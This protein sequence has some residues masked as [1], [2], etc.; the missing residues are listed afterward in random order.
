MSGIQGFRQ[1]TRDLG[2]HCTYQL[3]LRWQASFKLQLDV[4]S[5]L[6]VIDN[7]S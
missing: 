5:S 4:L 7:L 2:H 6:Q 1:V 3:G